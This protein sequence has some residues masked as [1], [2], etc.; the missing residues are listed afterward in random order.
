ML[1]FRSGYFSVGFISD[2]NFSNILYIHF[3]FVLLP[4]KCV[5]LLIMTR[6]KLFMR[7]IFFGKKEIY[8]FKMRIVVEKVTK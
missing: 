1:F 8:I 4:C 2:M 5:R 7:K 3:T 6:Y